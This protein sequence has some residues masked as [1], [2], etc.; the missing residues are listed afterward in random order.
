MVRFLAD[1]DIKHVYK[2]KAKLHKSN[3]R[4]GWLID[5]SALWTM[6]SHHTWFSNFTPLSQHTKVILGDNSTIPAV[7]SSH[8]NIKMLA[9][10]KWIDSILQDVLY[11]PDLHGNLLSVSHLVWCGTKVLFSGEACQVFD[12]RKSLILEGGLRNNLYIMNMHIADYVTANVT[13]LSP[14]LMDADQSITRALTTQLTFSSAPLT[15]WHHRLGHLNFRSIKHMVDEGLV[16]GMTVS[17][18]NTPL[19]PC[20]PC[21]EGKQTRDIIHKVAT[22]CAEH[23]LGCVHTDV[24]SP[25]PIPSHHGYRYFIM[26]IDDS[27]HF[28]S[29]SPLHEKS[30]VGK[31]LKA[32]ISW[33]E[34]ETGSKVKILCSDGGG[35][36]IAGHIKDYLKQRRIKHKV[37]TPN[38]PQHNGVAECFNRTLLNRTQAMLADTKLP[39]SYWLEALNYATH[40]HNLSPSRSVSSTPTLQYMGNIPDV[41]RLCTFSCI[42]HAHIPEKSCDKL[43]AHSLSCIFLGFSQQRT[44]FHLMHR[45]TCKFIES[46]DV[47][48]DEGGGQERIILEPNIDNPSN[49]IDSTADPPTSPTLTPPTMSSNPCPKCTTRPPIPD[50]DPRYNV[51]FYGPRANLANAEAPE[52]KTYDKAMASLDAIKWLAAYE[53]KMQTWKQ[54]DVYDVIPWPKGRKIV[55][56]KWVFHVKQ[57][58]D[59]T[60]Q[61]YKA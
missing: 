7:G 38:T 1:E 27:S 6:C 58:P 4:H 23:I 28:T 41:L 43:S 10:G 21:L 44:T 47:V 20:E 53:D 2:T 55:G 14:Q 45:P 32:F 40:L 5:S 56:S 12:C 25:L 51:S 17:N 29:V 54:L 35:K 22:M 19:D 31:L 11:M 50:D 36:Y 3:L 61:K 30:E 52:P 24:C 18:R 16:T 33:A 13:S 37:T 60:I 9:N 8:L 48:F 46:R 57:G 26:F 34:L 15:L 39:K 42:T 49:S 59:G